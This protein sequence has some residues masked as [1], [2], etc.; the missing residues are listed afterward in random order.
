MVPMLN[1]VN[2]SLAQLK[3]VGSFMFGYI[4]TFEHSVGFLSLNS[5]NFVSYAFLFHR[6]F[7]GGLFEG[8][9]TENTERSLSVHCYVRR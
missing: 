2:G 8:D 5:G 4:C 6:C 3:I 1:I 7:W 9:F